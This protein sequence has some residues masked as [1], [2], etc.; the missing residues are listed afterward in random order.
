M[1]G[2]KRGLTWSNA[3]KLRDEYANWRKWKGHCNTGSLGDVVAAAVKAS[4]YRKKT[5]PGDTKFEG[6]PEDANYLE[7]P[8]IPNV[9]NLPI[10]IY[11]EEL[12]NM[13]FSS[14]SAVVLSRMNKR[15]KHF[16]RTFIFPI[17]VSQ[18]SVNEG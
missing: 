1:E 9:A 17:K 8:S 7:K 14:I 18:L 2:K 13:S 3:Q 16:M 4:K 11:L 15:N 5:F 10:C 12:E 6:Y